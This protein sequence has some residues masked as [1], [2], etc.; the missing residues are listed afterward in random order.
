M[1]TKRVDP[2]ESCAH[3]LQSSKL[4]VSKLSVAELVQIHSEEKDTY[5]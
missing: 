3:G 5:Q 4:R 1:A 2:S